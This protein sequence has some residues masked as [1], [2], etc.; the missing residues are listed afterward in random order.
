MP[1][2]EVSVLVISSFV[3]MATPEM[4]CG[5]VPVCSPHA[6]LG[7]QFSESEIQQNL[8]CPGF[9]AQFFERLEWLQLSYTHW[10]FTSPHALRVRG[11]SLGMRLPW[12]EAT[13]VLVNQ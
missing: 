4:P 8:Q 9:L 12:D 11:W 7:F 2:G 10:P 5:T 3:E 13:C 6:S 1:C